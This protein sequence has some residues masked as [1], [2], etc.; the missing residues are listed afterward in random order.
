MFAAVEKKLPLRKYAL[1]P[2]KKP[3]FDK[4]DIPVDDGQASN[5]RCGDNNYRE[6][7]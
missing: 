6:G 1:E 5:H 4:R 3:A 7:E 2:A